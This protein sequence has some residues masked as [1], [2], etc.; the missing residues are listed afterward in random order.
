MPTAAITEV[1]GIHHTLL[2]VGTPW[3]ATEEVDLFL[4]VLLA[5]G[6]GRFE[7]EMVVHHRCHP[8]VGAEAERLR[9]GYGRGDGAFIRKHLFGPAGR[10]LLPMAA[11]LLF[12]PM[13]DMWYCRRRPDERRVHFASLRGRWSGLLTWRRPRRAVGDGG[14]R[15]NQPTGC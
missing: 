1:S 15:A 8:D 12:F 5:G 2:G 11:H 13:M 4:R 7:P 10:H 9:F 3:G 6:R 14:V